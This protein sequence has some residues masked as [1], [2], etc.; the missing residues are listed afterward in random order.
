LRRARDVLRIEGVSALLTIPWFQPEPIRILP[1]PESSW[2]PD[3][4]YI[5]AFGMMVALAVLVGSLIA[6][7]RAKREGIHPRIMGELLGYVLIGG[8]V[9]GH[10]LDAVFYHWDVVARDPLFVLKL[11]DGLSSFGGFVGGVLGAVIWTLHRRYSFIAFA[12]P[13]AYAFPFGWIFGRLGCFLAHDHPGAVTDFPLAVA[14]YHVAGMLPPWQ[15]RHDLGLYEA[16]FSMGVAALFF[17]LGRKTRRRGLYLALLPIL[18]A[19]VRFGLDFLRAT[20]V[21]QADPR[22][23]GLTPAHYGSI[24]LLVLGLA[25]LYLVYR[26]PERTI[27]PDARWAP[28]P[29]IEP[30]LVEHAS[31][32]DP[33]PT[34]ESA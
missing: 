28:E 16:L 4:I 10:M 33:E 20:D 18:Y 14:N 27:P 5:Y 12:D 17:A 22:F 26:R 1:L 29:E 24:L 23:L 30:A 13:I 15:T 3:G 2:L 6:D 19:P 9:L 7:H 31:A 11:W 21:P 8:F 25:V 34:H 32:D